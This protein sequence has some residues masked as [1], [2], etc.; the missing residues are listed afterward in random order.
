MVGVGGSGVG[1]RVGVDVG[2]EVAV[3]VKGVG[4]LLGAWLSHAETGVELRVVRRPIRREMT[5]R[6]R[7]REIPLICLGAK[8]FLQQ[9]RDVHLAVPIEDREEILG[10]A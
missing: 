1:V 5:K 4:V 9:R 6:N 7:A 3:G 8:I 2:V 10:G